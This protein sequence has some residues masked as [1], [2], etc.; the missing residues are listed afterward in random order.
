MPVLRRNS[1]SGPKS[2]RSWW[3][4]AIALLSVVTALFALTRPSPTPAEAPVAPPPTVDI[5]QSP[6]NA[7]PGTQAQPSTV[8][9]DVVIADVEGA[10]R[11]ADFRQLAAA[12]ATA[13]YTWD[14]R[15]SSYSE[16]YSRLRDWWDVLPAA[17]IP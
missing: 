13:I 2:R 1:L 5:P 4:A 16:V 15:T 8:A 17:P 6:A 11:T 7:S 9:P 12:A 10:P 14:T 3:I